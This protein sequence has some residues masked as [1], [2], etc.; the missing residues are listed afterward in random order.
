MG[1]RK[2][3][4]PV[5][6]AT[7]ATATVDRSPQPAPT[8]LPGIPRIP[9]KQGGARSSRAGTLRRTPDQTHRHSPLAPRSR[10]PRFF[11]APCRPATHGERPR[12]RTWS[13]NPRQ[14][15]GLVLELPTPGLP[16]PSNFTA[17]FFRTLPAEV[18]NTPRQNCSPIEVDSRADHH[19]PHGIGRVAP[20]REGRRPQVGHGDSRWQGRFVWMTLAP[21]TIPQVLLPICVMHPGP[22][23][24]PLPTSITSMSVA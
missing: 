12:P 8:P 24:R 3:R 2:P 15:Y 23:G 10:T 6:F 21:R 5:L 22:Y 17:A 18:P 4:P 9:Q 1:P 14:Q 19:V 16:V 13:N 7:N 20:R 11:L